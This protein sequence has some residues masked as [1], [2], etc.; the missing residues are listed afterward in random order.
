MSARGAA[1]APIPARP[2]EDDRAHRLGV[3]SVLMLPLLVPSA[4][5]SVVVQMLILG[6]KGLEGS[7]PMSVQ[8]ATGWVSLILGT[9]TLLAPTAVGVVLGTKARKLGNRL[10][11]FGMWIDGV[12]LVGLT[13]LIFWNTLA[14]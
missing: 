4:I 14:Q 3:W 2:T 13:V 6:T 8:G 1:G 12:I 11:T 9:A 5:A 10:G 7:E